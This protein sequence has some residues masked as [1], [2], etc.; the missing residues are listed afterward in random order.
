[1]T[2]IPRLRA[3]QVGGQ[4]WSVWVP[5]EL[6]GADAVQA[7]LEQ[8][9][10]VIANAENAAAG[11]G[12]TGALAEELFAAGCDVITL[13]DHVWGQKE[14]EMT[15]SSEKRLLRPVNYPPGTP[16]R[17]RCDWPWS[18]AYVSYE[19]YAMPCCMVSTPDRVNFGRIIDVP[20]ENVWNGE[21][22]AA[23]REQL[24][25]DTPPEV[26]AACSIYRGI[27]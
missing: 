4:F 13:G 20:V 22:Y 15:I 8:I 26:C 6:K 25:S 19:G 10:L 16:G 11:R 17:D 27:F 24:S 9:D 2:D 1:M 18:S 5:T 3:G 14:L 23:F 12:I 21:A 7:T